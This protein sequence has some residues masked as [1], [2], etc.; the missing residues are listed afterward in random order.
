MPVMT[1]GF[2][3]ELYLSQVPCSL[4]S[5]SMETQLQVIGLHQVILA[6]RLFS[7]KAQ[8]S[9]IFLSCFPSVQSGGADFHKY[10]KTVLPLFDTSCLLSY[11]HQESLA[12]SYGKLCPT[13]VY[14]LCSIDWCCYTVQNEISGGFQFAM[15]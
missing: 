3:Y 9:A 6:S 4:F 13:A 1:V 10:W 5:L 12:I 15:R 14:V 11:R 2:C 8:V 7:N